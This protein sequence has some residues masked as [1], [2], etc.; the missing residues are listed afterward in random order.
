MT[1]IDSTQL[2]PMA[3]VLGE[4][5]IEPCPEILYAD[6]IDAT[7]IETAFNSLV[8]LGAE[9]GLCK[10]TSQLISDND[11]LM[12]KTK[13]NKFYT[14]EEAKLQFG[15]METV[16]SQFDQIASYVT[17]SEELE[18]MKTGIANYNK[19]LTKLKN[20]CRKKLL[21]K[22]ADDFNALED[23]YDGFPTDKE[24]KETGT[25]FH[26]MHDDEFECLDGDNLTWWDYELKGSR[27]ETNHT[28]HPETGELL[29]TDYT[30]YNTF[31]IHKYKQIKYWKFFKKWDPFKLDPDVKTLEGMFEQVGATLPY[32]PALVI[33]VDVVD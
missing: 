30:N 8:D 13:S 21:E 5:E 11:S 28:Y 10:T 19:Q 20:N 4:G 6:Y 29:W 14:G 18:L 31:T 12:S 27:T 33:E 2:L 17:T 26:P 32:D 16:G 7:K 15:N 23:E 9:G 25:P 24:Y 1:E 3:T 22:A